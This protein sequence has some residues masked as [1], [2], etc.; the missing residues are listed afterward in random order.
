[1]ARLEKKLASMA[2]TM[3]D[4]ELSSIVRKITDEDNLTPMQS[5]AK[6]EW[7]QRQPRPT[8]I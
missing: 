2:A 4:A 5:A 1:M 3:L 6:V 8:T 7:I